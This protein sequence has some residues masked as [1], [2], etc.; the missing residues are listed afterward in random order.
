MPSILLALTPKLS[1]GRCHTDPT[2]IGKNP[3]MVVVHEVGAWGS[4]VSVTGSI[5]L[6]RQQIRLAS[7]TGHRE[8]D[9]PNRCYNIT[10]VKLV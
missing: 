7:V 5:L 9:M 8:V 2:P 3:A 6:W 4:E 10:T 1:S